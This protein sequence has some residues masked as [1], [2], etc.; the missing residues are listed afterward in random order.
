MN[1]YTELKQRQQQEFNALPLG[2]AFSQAQFAE[3]MENWGLDPDKDADKIYHI[4]AG[5]YVRKK[6]AELLHQTRARHD[7]EMSEAIAGDETGDGFIFDMF[8]CELEDHEF[9]YTM[10]MDSTL[11]A[12]CYTAE[13]IN[14]DK[15]LLPDNALE[16]LFALA[17][18]FE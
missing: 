5:A 9:G 13:D 8:L 3:M 11:D 6:D 18:L 10:D 7:K 4:G 1:R 15:R 16:L 14:S 12:L 17:G 2:F